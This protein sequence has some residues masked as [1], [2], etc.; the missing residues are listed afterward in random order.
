M[1]VSMQ[2]RFFAHLDDLPA[3]ATEWW[4]AVDTESFFFSRWWFQTLIEAA[5]DQGDEV[6]IGYLEDSSGPLALLP[7]RF[8]RRSVLFGLRRLESLTGP[9]SCLFHPLI[10][11]V[12][13]HIEIA[14]VL[15]KELGHAL[16]I[17]DSIWF[18]AVNVDWKA[19]AGF[20]SGLAEVGF[21]TT[22]YNHFGNWIEPLSGRS[23]QEYIASRDG[24]LQEILRRKG[25]AVTRNGAEFHIVSAPTEIGLGIEE[26]EAVYARSWKVA[27]PY[28]SFHASLIRNASAH[29]ALRLGI[30]SI[31]GQ[32]VATQLWIVWQGRATV[33]KLAHDQA[34]A[35]LSVG[36]VLTA[37]MIEALMEYDRVIE[38]DFGRGD[39]PYK[40]RWTTRRRQRV[41]LIAANPRS[42]A[43]SL[44]LIR[45]TLPQAL[46]FVKSKYLSRK[47]IAP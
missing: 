46:R 43:G 29:G 24:A 23:F 41:G 45:Q 5:L 28:P 35:K 8:T 13:K 17:S 2:F 47:D 1:M 10:A 14:R 40:L 3:V 9:Y 18:D 37:H 19:F 26:Y 11:D 6:A 30:C 7:C 33:L 16:R 44:Q 12:G 31:G 42:I 27:E 15:G 22:Q 20:K 32:P 25:R 21:I 34:F 39:D 38:I 4:R 36:S